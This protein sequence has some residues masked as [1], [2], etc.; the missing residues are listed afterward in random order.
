[1]STLALGA[2]VYESIRREVREQFD[3]RILEESNAL[4]R[5]FLE[6]GRDRLSAVV[7]ARGSGGGALAYGLLDPGCALLAGEIPAQPPAFRCADIGWV[8]LQ[9][10]DEDEAP[11][12][13]PE[14]I[15]ALVTRLPE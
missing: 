6:Q 1:M 7:T 8:E 15:R 12:G 9:E 11:E 5:I 10:N 14:R 13:A 4:R 2:F 3:D